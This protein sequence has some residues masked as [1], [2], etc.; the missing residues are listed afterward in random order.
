MV[1]IVQPILLWNPPVIA[2]NLEK[3]GLLNLEVLEAGVG[4]HWIGG[5]TL[6]LFFGWDAR[7]LG[8]IGQV[9]LVIETFTELIGTGRNLG[10]DELRVVGVLGGNPE[11][12]QQ[13]PAAPAWL[14][15]TGRD[16]LFPIEDLQFA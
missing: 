3:I 16:E 6:D 2:K 8:K 9:K 12:E 1:I 11:I 10:E 5:D 7:G 4:S 13:L 14:H 15:R